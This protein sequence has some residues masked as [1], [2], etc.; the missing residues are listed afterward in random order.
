MTAHEPELFSCLGR[1]EGKVDLVLTHQKAYEDTLREL[2]VRTRSLA[3]WRAW[4]HGVTATIAASV[5]FV[6]TAFKLGGQQ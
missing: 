6:V 3:R 1:L 4:T 5:S 2:S